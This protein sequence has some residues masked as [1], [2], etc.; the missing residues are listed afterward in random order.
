VE[1][2]I[3]DDGCRSNGSKRGAIPILLLI[4]TIWGGRKCETTRRSGNLG[5]E[6]SVEHHL[7]DGGDGVHDSM[8][9]GEGSGPVPEPCPQPWC[10]STILDDRTQVGRWMGVS[11]ATGVGLKTVEADVTQSQSVTVQVGRL[12][13][14]AFCQSP[15]G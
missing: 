3:D 8:G 13:A 4:F 15:E 5:T 12:A 11:S 7:G 14:A 10:R 1:A 2:I 6:S 9:D